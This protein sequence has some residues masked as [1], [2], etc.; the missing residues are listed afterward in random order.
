MF[1]PLRKFFADLFRTESKALPTKAQPSPSS[2]PS[3]PGEEEPVYGIIPESERDPEY[4]E[5]RNLTE[6]MNEI[7]GTNKHERQSF[8]SSDSE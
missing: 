7:M 4:E 8:S 6:Q 1:E 5:W 2:A 3:S